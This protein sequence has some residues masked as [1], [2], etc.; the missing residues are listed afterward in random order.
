MV[1]NTRLLA[2]VL[3]QKEPGIPVWLIVVIGLVLLGIIIWALSRAARRPTDTRTDMY[4]EAEM[5]GGPAADEGA[6]TYDTS[7]SIPVTSGTEAGTATPVVDEE[8]GMTEDYSERGRIGVPSYQDPTP[9][10]APPPGQR[11]ENV[12]PGDP[13]WVGAPSYQDTTPGMPPPSGVDDLTVIEGIGPRIAG[14][15]NQ[16]GV[17]TFSQ[18][19]EMTPG[20]LTRLL[21]ENDIRMAQ[22]ETWPEQARLAAMGEM[23]RLY[24]LQARLRGGRRT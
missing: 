10:T 11:V 23:D 2:S 17:M 14:I 5:R 7:G 22:T 12:G 20:Q 16:A 6:Q 24:E 15:L 8:T 9:G 19:A 1:S 18:L 4:N 21:D 3:L 13:D